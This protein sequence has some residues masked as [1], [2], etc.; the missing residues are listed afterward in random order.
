MGDTFLQISGIRAPEAAVEKVHS[1]GTSRCMGGTYVESRSRAHEG[2]PHLSAS[3]GMHSVSTLLTF[4]PVPI[5]TFAG[6]RGSSGAAE[7]RGPPAA[8]PFDV[9]RHRCDWTAAYDVRGLRWA[10][11]LRQP[12][13]RPR[14]RLWLPGI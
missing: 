9:L 12:Q 11:V 1:P 3:E 6:F 8:R 13:R 14:L 2:P 7:R 5:P 10:R 4:P